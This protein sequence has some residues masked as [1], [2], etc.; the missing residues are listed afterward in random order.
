VGESQRVTPEEPLERNH[1]DRHDGQPYQREGRLAASETGVE[2]TRRRRVS[3]ASMADV[4]PQLTQHR[5]S[6]ARRGRMKLLPKQ[7]HQ[8]RYPCQPPST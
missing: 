7:Y 3:E 1:T 4:Q 6:S 2:E 5:E 8:P